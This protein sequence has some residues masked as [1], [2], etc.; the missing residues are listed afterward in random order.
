MR[1]RCGS[2]VKSHSFCAMYSLKMSVCRVP[3]SV[4]VSTPARSAAT[5]IMQKIGTAGPLIVIEVVTSPRSMPSKSTSMSAARVDRHAAVPHLAEG[6]RVVGVPADQRRHVE[7]DAESAAA[8]TQDHLVALVG[9]P[10]V[11]EAGELPDCPGA[12]AVAGRVQAARVGELAG[13]LPLVGA[14]RRVDLDAA[15]G[16]EVGVAGPR[17]RRSAPASGRVR[18]GLVAACVLGHT[19]N[20]RTSYY[21]RERDPSSAGVRSPRASRRTGRSSSESCGQRVVVERAEPE[22]GRRR[23]RRWPARRRRGP[24]R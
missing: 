9:L 18:T 19:G 6:H 21:L 5:I 8:T 22:V 2:G 4:P 1:R 15:E 23:G 20:S 17:P 7:G 3:L 11:A 16:R 14:V 10:G 12:A 13:P 24:R